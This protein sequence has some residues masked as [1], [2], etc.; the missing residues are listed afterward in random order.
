MI[1]TQFI[2]V[3]ANS[4]KKKKNVPIHQNVFTQNIKGEIKLPKFAN[5]AFS[6]KNDKICGNMQRIFLYLSSLCF[7][8]NLY[9]SLNILAIIK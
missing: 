5:Y 9:L 3:E 2:I 7:K 6:P 4:K 8:T 1:S